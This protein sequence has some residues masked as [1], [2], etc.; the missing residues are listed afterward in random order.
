MKK[1]CF[2]L[3]TLI[4]L[5]YVQQGYKIADAYFNDEIKIKTSGKLSDIAKNVRPVPLEK[6]DSGAV[7]QVRQVR[8][9]GDHL[10]LL[11]DNRLLQFDMHGRFIR[12]IAGG[13]KDEND[14][15]MTGYA[16]NTEM[17]RIIAIDSLHHI[18][19]YDYDGNRIAGKRIEHP[20]QKLTAL[21]FHDG[22]LWV[23]AETLVE[24]P[25]QPDAACRKIRHDLYQLDADLNEISRQTLRIADTGRERIFTGSCV[26][27]LLTD[28]NG[29]YAYAPPFD[30]EQLL[31]DT[32]YITEQ[33]KF[34]LLYPKGYAGK[35]C[36]YPVR[37]GTRHLIATCHHNAGSHVTFCYDL[38]K[39]TAWLLPKGFR[40]D[41]Y[42]TGHVTDFQPM[43]LYGQS[44]CFIKSGRDLSRKYPAR[45]F[46]E[47]LPV[48]FI[49]N[50]NT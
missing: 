42:E 16:L 30:T 26:T 34:P 2:L 31:S 4:A 14:A 17:K 50:L 27:E 10:F 9:D 47:D 18:T 37:K 40:D 15:C 49:V 33:K 41:F 28:E 23:T 46:S 24:E 35:A 5:I 3:L 45:A 22:Y 44:Y 13:G 43:D 29:V 11:S 12:Q 7:R 25:D 20:W 8:R 21:A 48:L 38:L 19:Q 6:P 32:L 39:F 1:S 36:I